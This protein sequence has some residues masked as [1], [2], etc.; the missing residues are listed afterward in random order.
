MF[1]KTY[2]Q[3]EGFTLIELLVVILIIGV[4]SAIAIPAFLNQRKEAVKA[5]MVS[6]LKNASTV[7]ENE[8]IKN[9]GKYP[10]ALPV[11]DKQS[12]SNNVY[13]ETARSSSESY[14]LTVTNPA[15]PATLSFSSMDGGMMPEGK[16]CADSKLS[17][18]STKMVLASKKAIVVQRSG[19]DGSSVAALRATGLTQID[20]IPEGTLT[21]AKAK[22]YDLIV[23]VGNVW[24]PWGADKDVAVQAYNS[25][26]KVMTDGNDSTGGYVPLIGAGTVARQSTAGTAVNLQLEPTYNSGLSPAFPYTFKST[27]FSSAD[28]WQ[29]PKAASAGTVVIADSQDPQ[30]PG[31]KCLTI[32][33]QTSSGGGRWFHMIQFPT[34]FSSPDT[35]PAVNGVNW[36]LQ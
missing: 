22:Q 12:D 30:A 8:I 33:G 10:A 31:E 5:S 26:S 29:C 1:K 7:M 35:N 25:G 15:Y 13:L 14:C 32:L 36:L 21:L 27:S 3:E 11:Y 28:T 19:T 20:V 4:L 34:N 24:A 9:A 6:D 23:V 2:S 17:G 18:T 16:T